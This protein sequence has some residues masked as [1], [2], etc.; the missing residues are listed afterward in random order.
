LLDKLRS[1]QIVEKPIPHYGGNAP[2]K[3]TQ[4]QPPQYH[5]SPVLTAILFFV[6]LLFL[7]A[8]TSLGCLCVRRRMKAKAKKANQLNRQQVREEEYES[9]VDL[10]EAP[11]KGDEIVGRC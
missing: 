4:P 5:Q 10:E 3:H 2:S 8:L 11:I 9:N 6:A 1:L 7:I